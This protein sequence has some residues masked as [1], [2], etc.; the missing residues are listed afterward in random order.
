[1]KVENPVAG[2]MV[3][4]QFKDLENKGYEI[5]NYSGTIDAE[6]IIE[7]KEFRITLKK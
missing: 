4:L 7:I 1:M 5:Q 6:G 3:R 2:K